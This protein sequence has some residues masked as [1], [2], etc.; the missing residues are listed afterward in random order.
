MLRDLVYDYRTCASAHTLPLLNND[1]Q[2]QPGKMESDGGSFLSVG[3]GTKTTYFIQ[4]Q[5]QSV[6]PH[7]SQQPLRESHSVVSQQQQ[8]TTFTL[9]IS[10]RL[11]IW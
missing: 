3:P 4:K 1:T 2:A 8:Q 9:A 6:F 5:E 7:L 11:T 10:Q